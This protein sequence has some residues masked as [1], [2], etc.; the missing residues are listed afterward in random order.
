MHQH[1]FILL[2]VVLYILP[3][4]RVPLW[5][6]TR[7]VTAGWGF[8]FPGNKHPVELYLL[9][10]L[11]SGS[12]VCPWMHIHAIL[13]GLQEWNWEIVHL[14]WGTVRDLWQRYSTRPCHSYW[15]R[16]PETGVCIFPPSWMAPQEAKNRE[17]LKL[18]TVTTD[19]G[20]LL[21]KEYL[22]RR[23]NR[24]CIPLR[25]QAGWTWVWYFN[26]HDLFARWLQSTEQY[27][28]YMILFLLP[29]LFQ[30]FSWL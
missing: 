29:S 11:E 2:N 27:F 17:S 14:S 28:A 22:W 8:R 7:D 18:F 1:Y 5:R 12:D 25:P 9:V 20:L 4:Y 23:R 21:K 13:A 30:W 6:S 3:V 15:W 19:E 24:L 26:Q 10:P 16:Y